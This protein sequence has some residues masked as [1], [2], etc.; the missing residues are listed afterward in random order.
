MYNCINEAIVWSREQRPERVKTEDGFIYI[1]EH[2]TRLVKT[3]ISQYYYGMSAKKELY[4]KMVELG[5][6]N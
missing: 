3:L 4:Y 2:E 1:D 6:I 5:V